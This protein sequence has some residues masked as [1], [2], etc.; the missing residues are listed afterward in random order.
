MSYA[1]RCLLFQRVVL[2]VIDSL[3]VQAAQTAACNC[4]HGAEAR[5]ARWLLMTRERSRSDE[6]QLTQDF[7]ADML[8]VRRV[9][10][11][12]AAS[13]LRLR[14]LIQYH[15]GMITILDQRGLKAA[16]CICYRQVAPLVL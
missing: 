9:T 16:S 10:V 12:V 5:L 11:T 15:R 8:G 1:C 13:A 3:M 6:F 14:K 7:I 2:H 4:Y